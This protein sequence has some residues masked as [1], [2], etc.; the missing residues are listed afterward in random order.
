M[1]W[2]EVL[3]VAAVL[4]G[5]GGGAFLVAQ[6]PAFW[7]EFGSRV[8]KSLWPLL[9]ALVAKRMTADQE[10]ALADCLRRGGTWDHVRKRCKD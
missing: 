2:L 1:T 5:L 4:I 8:A 9:L 6:R 10:A 7:V 3:A